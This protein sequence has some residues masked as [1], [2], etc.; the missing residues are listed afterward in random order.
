MPEQTKNPPRQSRRKFLRTAGLVPAALYLDGYATDG[1]QNVGNDTGSGAMIDYAAPP[2]D[3]VRVGIIGAGR[4]G[5]PMMRLLFAI[6]GVTVAAVADPWGPAI[7]RT[8]Q[9]FDEH[10]VG[11][12]EY[13]DAGEHD[14]RN[15][16]ARDDIDAVYIATPW[17]WHATMAVEARDAGKHALVEVPAALIVQLREQAAKPVWDAFVTDLEKKN[18]P[19]REILDFVLEEAAKLTAAN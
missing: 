14:Y 5:L 2:L 3:T 8:R 17:K 4:R 9:Q 11:Q 7:E 18:L 13:F 6:D 1:G 15:L 12:P 19:G 10:G 16:L